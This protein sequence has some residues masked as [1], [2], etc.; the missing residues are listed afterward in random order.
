MKF[1][2]GEGSVFMDV[3]WDFFC[4]LFGFEKFTDLFCFLFRSR[5][6]NFFVCIRVDV[7]WGEFLVFVYKYL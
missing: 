3:Y 6:D 1:F 5:L 2:L 7:L 4:F